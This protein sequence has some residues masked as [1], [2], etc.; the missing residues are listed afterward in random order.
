VAPHLTTYYSM[1]LFVSKLDSTDLQWD[2]ALNNPSKNYEIISKFERE[3]VRETH[4]YHDQLNCL[5]F[6]FEDEDLTKLS[7][8]KSEMEISALQET[9]IIII[10]IIIIPER[11]S[12]FAPII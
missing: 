4:K 8:I 9:I 6:P 2:D 11:F 5:Y 1:L 3:A 10:I 12:L 7:P